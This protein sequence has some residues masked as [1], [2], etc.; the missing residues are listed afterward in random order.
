MVKTT[1]GSFR[2]I[3]W[4][5][6]IAETIVWAAM[7]YSFPAL[8]LEWEKDFGWSKTELTGAF[9]ISLLVSAAASPI[10]GRFIDRGYGRYMLVGCTI[11]GAACLMLLSQVTQLWQFYAVWFL[12]GIAMAGCLYDAC[13]AILTLTMGD[14][15]KRSITLVT[16]AAGFAGT[17]SFP[18]ANALAATVGW[19]G[20]LMVF[21]GVMVVVSAPLFWSACGMANDNP[22]APALP[23]GKKSETILRLTRSP[24]FWCLSLCF[25]ALALNH[26]ML[27]NHMLPLLNER[28]VQPETAILAASM[29]GPMQV[30]GRLVIMAVEKHVSTSGLFVVC[31]LALA[32]ASISIYGAIAIP[33]LLVGFVVFQGAG[34]GFVSILRPVI[35]AEYLGRKDY[36]LIAGVLAGAYLIGF[37]LAP[38]VGSLIW[39]VGDYDR[40]IEFALFTSVIAFLSLLMARLFMKRGGKST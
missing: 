15:A 13:F 6:A 3:V 14:A 7:Y 8:L 39:E 25:I 12:L 35:I 21:A 23:T 34:N 1:Q 10:A 4:P 32:T 29:I 36:G 24:L 11:F 37:A 18:S 17:V 40:V 20:A 31:T 30:M 33:A 19:R 16:L 26:G 27:I 38:I 9:T 5:L 28:G 22:R 2:R